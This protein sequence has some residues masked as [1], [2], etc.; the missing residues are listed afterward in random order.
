M[1]S[2]FLKLYKVA[3]SIP[4]HYTKNYRGGVFHSCINM[5]TIFCAIG[6]ISNETGNPT[7][8][9]TPND[10]IQRDVNPFSKPVLI[11][12]RNSDIKNPIATAIIVAKINGVNFL[13]RFIR[14]PLMSLRHNPELRCGQGEWQYRYRGLVRTF[15][16]VD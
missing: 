4:V 7:A 10:F 5:E 16:I 3:K 13:F 8:I 2:I 1:N 6:A 11:A 9:A 12:V 15:E 14:F